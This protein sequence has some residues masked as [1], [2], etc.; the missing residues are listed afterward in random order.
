MHIDHTE[1]RILSTHI[2]KSEGDYPT[3][4]TI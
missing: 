4:A 2:E 3:L 1:Q